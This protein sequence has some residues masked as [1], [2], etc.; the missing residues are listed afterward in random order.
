M[1]RVGKRKKQLPDPSHFNRPLL[2]L[3]IASPWSP[4]QNKLW[5]VLE[6]ITCTACSRM[7][8]CTASRVK[9]SDS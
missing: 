7:I 6:R 9:W 4:L 1:D 8:N 3:A 2:Q 5:A